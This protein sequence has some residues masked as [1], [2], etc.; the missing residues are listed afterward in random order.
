ME[1]PELQ[2]PTQAQTGGAVMKPQG[3][4]LLEFVSQVANGQL[5]LVLL[6][7][8]LRRVRQAVRETAQQLTR[9]QSNIRSELV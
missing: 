7:R 9:A 3:S 4:Y 8:V 2:L 6:H 1:P 5:V